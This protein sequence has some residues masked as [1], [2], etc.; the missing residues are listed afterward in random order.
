MSE[1]Q[2]YERPPRGRTT[3]P[4]SLAL[5]AADNPRLPTLRVAPHRRIDARN[6]PPEGAA[7]AITWE[8]IEGR[9]KRGNDAAAPGQIKV[10]TRT[11]DMIEVRARRPAK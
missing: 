11:S 2:S 7:V 8:Q 5:P 9:N 1:R 4:F 6:V 3:P 10:F